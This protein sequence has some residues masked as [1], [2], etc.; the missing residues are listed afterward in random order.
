MYLLLVSVALMTALAVATAEAQQVPDDSYN[1]PIANPAYPQNT[2]P[3]VAID[4]AHHNF[5]RMTAL[6]EGGVVKEPARYRPFATLL[7]RDGYRVRPS[8]SQFSAQSLQGVDVLVIANPRAKSTAD[9]APNYVLP[10]PSAFT[11]AEIA[12]VRTWV[13]NGGSLFLIADHFPWPGSTEN[14]AAAFGIRTLNGYAMRESSQ[15]PDFYFRR[16]GSSEILADHRI[17]NGRTAA[18]RVDKVVSFTGSAFQV[19]A[20]RNAQP[21]LTFGPNVVSIQTQRAWT[22]NSSTPRIPV[23]GGPQG[24]VMRA[25]EG[26]VA[27]FGE[28]AMFTAQLKDGQKMGMNAPYAEQNYKFL[29]NVSHW[30]SGLL[31]DPPADAAKPT[32]TLTTPAEGATYALNQPLNADYSCQD[33]A[34]GSGLQ[35]CRGT[36]ANGSAIDT[37]SVGTKTFTVTATDNAGNQTSISRTYSVVNDQP[38]ADNG[39]VIFHTARDGNYEVYAMDSNGSNPTNLTNHP[40]VD[41]YSAVS[42]DGKKMVFD[43][44]RS[45]NFEIYESNLDGSN[46]TKLTN[47]PANEFSAAYSSDGRKIAFETTRDGNYEIYE[48]NLD[49]S[50]PTN[51][52]NHPARE[53]NVLYSPDGKKIAFSTNRDGWPEIYTM[54]PDGSNP[55]NLTNTPNSSDINI[56][57][58][59]DGKKIAFSTN[60][61]GNFEVYIMNSDGSNPTNL[62]RNSA[63]DVHPA[64]SRDGKKIA[65]S[66]TR[67]G[68][69]EVYTMNLDG[70]NPTNL[71]NNPSD[72]FG[73][74]W[75]PISLTW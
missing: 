1:P 49:G 13:H 32:I 37:A 5:H 46:P 44:N 6:A 30:L 16:S 14:L 62:T 53:T 42:P 52:T 56:A 54:N 74:D 68:N 38:P 75:Q 40:A 67:D 29:L 34:G 65:F 25:G 26:R 55:T 24:A 45:G 9:Q 57:Y 61:N 43:S 73:A 48:S 70:S 8:T 23:A 69:Y 41:E 39:G 59:P 18:E 51:L 20:D 66:T 47:T 22:W 4:E 27:M 12:A 2:G 64:F 50:N 15:D 31:V 3:V 71:T 11:D 28:A 72:D 7:Q 21:L 19:D 10:T 36:V 35:S 58:S 33:E 17:T 60:R 63:R